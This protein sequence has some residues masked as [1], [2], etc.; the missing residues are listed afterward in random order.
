MMLCKNPNPMAYSP[1]DG[2]D[3][4]DLVVLS[5]ARRDTLAPFLFIRC[6][7]LDEAIS[8]LNQKPRKLL[9]QF[10]Y[11]TSSISSTES[12]VNLCI[13]KSWSVMDM[14]LTI[15]KSDLSEKIRWEYAKVVVVS[16]LLFGCIIWTLMNFTKSLMGTKQECYMMFW[17]NSISSTPLNSSSMTTYLPSQKPS[18]LDRWSKGELISYILLWTP[19]H[20]HTS[21]GWPA[22]KLYTSVSVQ[23]LNGI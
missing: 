2:P 11:F 1:D 16:L 17:T 9:D 21:V 12:N 8:S 3:F 22:K 13:G 20:G 7:N 19:A 14:L 18:K 5:L 4:F 6:L 23:S 15:G 10:T